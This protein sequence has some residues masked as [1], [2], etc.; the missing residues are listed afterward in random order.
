[1]ERPGEN[2]DLC[3]PCGRYSHSRFLPA[4]FC[5]FVFSLS[6]PICLLF[7][8][9]HLLFLPAFNLLLLFFFFSHASVLAPRSLVFIFFLP[10][11]FSFFIFPDWTCSLCLCVR[12]ILR[13]RNWRHFACFGGCA[14]QH[15]ALQTEL[16]PQTSGADSSTVQPSRIIVSSN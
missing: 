2:Y 10:F 4:L 15:H 3:H 5:G 16:P 13:F 14:G 6:H 7:A 9:S 8:H 12:H 1:M 11:S